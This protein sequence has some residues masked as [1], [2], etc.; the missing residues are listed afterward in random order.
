MS[1]QKCPLEFPW[2]RKPSPSHAIYLCARGTGKLRTQAGLAF[3]LVLFAIASA[4]SAAAQAQASEFAEANLSSSDDPLAATESDDTAFQRIRRAKNRFEFG[5]CA[6]TLEELDGL[7]APQALN[8]EKQSMEVHRMKGVCLALSGEQAQ[9]ELQ[10]ER[11]L[12]IAPDYELDSFRTP[13]AI[14]ELFDRIKKDIREELARL[15]AA[16]TQQAQNQPESLRVVW[17]ER[18]LERQNTPFAVVFLPFGLAQWTNQE[19]TKAVIVGSIQLAAISANVGSY[20]AMQG[21]KS[22]AEPSASQQEAYGWLQTIQAGA[23]IA[24]IATY[25]YGVGDAWWNHEPSRERL[26]AEKRR[27]LAGEEAKES[28]RRIA[29]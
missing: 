5:D 19:S 22:V 6:A 13:P 4:G 23:L 26:V 15:Q 17:V 24:A 12:H 2:E 21:I 11:L 7:D 20:W 25:L 16:Q 3:W 29:P 8:D 1:R 28:L 18:E 9:A 27:E 10:F 14:M